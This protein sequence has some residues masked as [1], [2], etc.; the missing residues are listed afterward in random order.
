[1]ILLLILVVMITIIQMIVIGTHSLE[2]VPRQPL[3]TPLRKHR[4]EPAA[5]GGDGRT[6]VQDKALQ[7]VCIYIYI[8]TYI[9]IYI[10][11]HI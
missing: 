5:K 9:Y 3:G 2:V 6:R 1:M 8:Y 11:I 7:D 10:Y 4:N